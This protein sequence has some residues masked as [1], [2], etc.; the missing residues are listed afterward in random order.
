MDIL[1]PVQGFE[2]KTISSE[3][4]YTGKIVNVR[5][6]NVISSDGREYYREII[7]HPGGVVIAPVTQN[8]EIILIKQWRHA[9]GRELI[10]LPA[11]KL[12]RKEDILDAAK[13]ELQEETGFAAKSWE[14]LG[15]VYSTPGFCNEVLHLYKAWDLEPAVANPDAGEIIE[16]YIVS[17]ENAK[18]LIREGKINDAKTLACLAMVFQ[19]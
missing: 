1:Q 8:N 17:F 15:F 18:K 6:E 9:I 5:F 10:E 13:R 3:V 4:K 7:D 19:F 12:D 2:E 14:S 16:P 11:G